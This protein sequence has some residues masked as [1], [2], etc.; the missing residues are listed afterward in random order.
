MY[1][2]AKEIIAKLQ[3]MNPDEKVLVRVWYKSDVQELAIDRNMPQVS[4]S[5]AESTLALIDRTHDGDIGI[6]W[7]VVQ[8]GIET[9]R[10]C[11]FNLSMQHPFQ[12]SLSVF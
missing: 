1:A 3:K 2:T 9:V 11:R 12:L 8:S 4:A 10:S 6:N 7:D 5:E